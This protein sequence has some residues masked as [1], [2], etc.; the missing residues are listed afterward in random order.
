MNWVGKVYLLACGLA[1]AVTLLSYW[2]DFGWISLIATLPTF[3]A[4]T[5]LVPFF[6]GARDRRLAVEKRLREGKRRRT[7]RRR[8]SGPVPAVAIAARA[9][10]AERGGRVVVT[11]PAAPR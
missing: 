9:P 11:L 5:V 1:L 8:M 2:S 7:P 6:L 3:L 10:L 4:V